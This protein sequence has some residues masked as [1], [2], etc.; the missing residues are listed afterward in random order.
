MVRA[1]LEL[2]EKMIAPL[3][4][5]LPDQTLL[6]FILTLSHG[7]TVVTRDAWAEPDIPDA[8]RLHELKML[9]EVHTA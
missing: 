9:N 7:L 4:E 3:P 1:T 8:M 5:S 6:G 2:E